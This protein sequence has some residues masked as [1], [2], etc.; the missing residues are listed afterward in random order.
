VEYLD[1]NLTALNI[2]DSGRVYGED[3]FSYLSVTRPSRPY[4]I[5]FLDP[6]YGQGLAFKTIER[7]A[8]WSGFGEGT[9]GIAK[10]FKKEKFAGPPPL[11]L[12]DVRRIGDDN[13][14]FFH[15]ETTAGPTGPARS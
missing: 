7:L 11:A 15:M 5:V 1:G 13:L 2:A 3:V 9:L 12:L 8:R 10:T 4:E 6:P 14:S